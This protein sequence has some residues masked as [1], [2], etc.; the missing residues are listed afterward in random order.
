MQKPEN[1][2]WFDE[3]TVIVIIFDHQHL[4]SFYDGGVPQVIALHGRPAN[5]VV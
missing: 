4:I 1:A 5:S 3:N 2:R